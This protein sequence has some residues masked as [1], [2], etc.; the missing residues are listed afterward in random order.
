MSE[1]DIELTTNTICQVRVKSCF[2]Y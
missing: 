1:L 2:D